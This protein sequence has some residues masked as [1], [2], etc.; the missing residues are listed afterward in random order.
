MNFEF[1][2]EQ[3]VL[4]KT[5]RDYLRGNFPLKL[6]GELEN[7]KLG[8][9]PA[10]WKSMAEMGWLGLII[11]EEYGGFGMNFL[12]LGV[13]L[14]EMGRAAVLSPYFSTVV[15]G[16]LPLL[17][18]GTEEQK[19]R[20]LPKIADGE[21]IFTLALLEPDARYSA[22]DVRLKA[23]PDKEGY[24][25][26]GTKLFVPYAHLADYIMV[27][28]RTGHKEKEED[29]IT[30]F[31]VDAKSRGISHK[32]LK[33]MCNDKL[34]EV[35]FKDVVVPKQMILGELDNGWSG[36]QRAMQRA[37]VA[38]CCEMVGGAQQVLDMTVSY[39]KQ[40]LQF[41]RPIGSFQAIQHYCA[42]MATDIDGA[43]LVTYQAAW[44]I[45]RGLECDLEIAIAKSWTGNVYRRTTA[46][47]HQIH[48]AIGITMDYDLH[49][50]SR[51]AKAAEVT[52]G[53]ADFWQETIAREMGLS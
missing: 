7:D 44:M 1:S 13:L 20:F 37:S 6:V 33:T 41:G 47:S 21:L 30:V 31:I 32:V 12:D 17:D 8:Y 39:C 40:R 38:S 19:N 15:L 3:L 9:S 53:D 4:Q 23:T 22:G 42:N 26:N 11:P 25:L 28:A 50:Y 16:A 2:E 24:T 43:K 48:G 27:V 45:S 35:V 46:M 49:F 52:F 34:C 14:E 51:R 18:I 36:I 29:G 5:A 10:M